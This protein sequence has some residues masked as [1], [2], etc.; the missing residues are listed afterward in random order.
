MT[1]LKNLIGKMKKQACFGLKTYQKTLAV[2][3]LFVAGGG[4]KPQKTSFQKV[5]EDAETAEMRIF[6]VP[7]IDPLQTKIA[8]VGIPSVKKL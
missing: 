2:G 7:K 1:I 5:V 8:K 3:L 6:E 4:E